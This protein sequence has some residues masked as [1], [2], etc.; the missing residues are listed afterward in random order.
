MEFNQSRKRDIRTPRRLVL[1]ENGVKS[2]IKQAQVNM[3]R[4]VETLGC[5]QPFDNTVTPENCVDVLVAHRVSSK[6]HI[7]DLQRAKELQRDA[8][9]KYLHN[10]S[11]LSS[12]KM[13]FPKGSRLNR[14]RNLLHD[15]FDGF[16]VDMSDTGY[17]VSPGE[18]YI[19]SGGEVSL[20]SKLFCKDHWT[21]TANC[22]DDAV[23]FIYHTSAFKRAAKQHIGR[24][25]RE[26]R[27]KLYRRFKHKDDIGFSIFR[28]LLISRVLIITDGSRI[29]SVPK[30]NEQRR[31][32]NIEAMFS[33]ICQRA[34]AFEILKVLAYYGNDMS[35]YFVTTTAKGSNSQSSALG[36][37]E[38][39]A[40]YLH[41][42]MIK[43]SVYST[44]DFQN[45]S[46]SVTLTAV[47]GLFPKEVSNILFRLRSHIVVIG[48]EF[49]S[50]NMLSSMG[51][52]FT[53]EVMTALLYA[54]ASSYTSDCRVYG[55]DVIIPNEFASG[56][57]ET[58][59]LIDFRV[60]EKKTF[61]NSFFRESCG[62]FYSDH[63]S[64]YITSFDFGQI[65]SL[66]DVIITCNKLSVIIDAKQISAELETKLV[67]TRDSIADLVHASRKGP[68][69]VLLDDKLRYLSSYIFDNG[70]CKKQR[71]SKD[72]RTLRQHY[73]E[74]TDLYFTQCQ[75]EIADFG[76]IY[77][78]FF[79]PSRSRHV[80]TETKG[81][82]IL[83][84]ATYSG[85]RIKAS[86]KGKQFG[87]WVDIPAFVCSDGTVT[88]VPNCIQHQ[89]SLDV[90]LDKKF[91]QFVKV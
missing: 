40:Q 85:I 89:Q 15:W 48:D 78:P 25:T 56:F 73:V 65:I 3:T 50:L 55:D 5:Y 88:L 41:G 45:A 91:S 19:S 81:L 90:L 24:V 49:H 74:R 18:T 10:D 11:L 43:S 29:A 2:I 34:V 6:F 72:L 37:I 61:I 28:H 23:V 87:R 33:V 59:K 64:A 84:P 71:R 38:R 52:G 17:E 54:I 75:L 16:T 39:S 22:L 21:V 30:S 86:R 26:E 60:N 53:F 83:L 58:C 7:E 67:K 12:G 36:V 46:N 47:E 62:Y 57:V 79:V 4:L 14:A 77:I 27:R 42:R 51:N 66:S 31:V 80:F 13:S 76:L 32:I 35:N 63:L 20:L 68:L 9:T 8:Y 82:D 1:Q 69:P 44:I 70:Y